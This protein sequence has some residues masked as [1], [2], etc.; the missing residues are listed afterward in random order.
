SGPRRAGGVRARTLKV[1]LR[2][3][4]RGLIALAVRHTH[5][6]ADVGEQYRVHVLEH[7]GAH[8][9]HLAGHQLFGHAGPEVNRARNLLA[10]HDLFHRDG[11]GDVHRHAGVV[12]FTVSG[13]RGNDGI[14]VADARL[15]ARLWNVV[16][17]GAQRDDRLAGP[18]RRRP[19][20]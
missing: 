18:P 8:E 1:E 16:D 20:R 2:A 19:R 6:V 17:V 10:L 7:S 11:R 13:R 14:L 15:L 4:Q 12:A 9:I 5:V 3:D